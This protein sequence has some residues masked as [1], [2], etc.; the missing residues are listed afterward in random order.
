MPDNVA[1]AQTP[2]TQQE[3]NDLKRLAAGIVRA[4]GNRFI[5]ELMRDQGITL[6]ANKNDFERNLSTA[7]EDGDLRLATVAAWLQSVEG[8]GNQHVYLYAL[9]STITRDLTEPKLRQAVSSAGLGHLWNVATVLAFP[10][11]PELISISFTDGTLRLVWQEASPGW[12]PVPEKDFTQED[13]LDTYEYRAYRKVERRA[14]TRFEARKELGLAAL[15][16]ADPIQGEEHGKAIAEAKRVVGNLMNLSD[17]EN[18]QL[19]ISVVSRNMD[20]RNV[21]SNANPNPS[22]KT[23]MARLSSGGSYVE[24]AA[25]S[26]DRGYAEESAIR[27]VRNSIRE[28]QLPA[29]RGATGVFVFQPGTGPSAFTRPLRV[30]LYSSDD[31]IRLWAQMDS[32]EVW[33]VLEEVSA[34]RANT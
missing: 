28:P 11:E 29:F 5:K 13:G 2:P 24:F 25:N 7:I 14:I 9:T 3:I 10:D 18:N 16:I 17:L 4:Q 23:Q 19:D 15:F 1:N 34:Y 27:D 21:P 12:T 22:I 30:Q 8:W 26:K 20:Q 32:V 6:G 31:R 33:N